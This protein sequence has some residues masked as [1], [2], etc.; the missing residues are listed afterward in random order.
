MA[1]SSLQAV[2]GRL[3]PATV[4]AAA[5]VAAALAVVVLVPT[6]ARASAYTDVLRAYQLNGSVPPCQFTSQQ[7]AA[8]LKEEDTY[9]QEYFADFT[10]A[11][12]AALSARAS[13][14]CNSRSAQRG[15]LP[16]T[17]GSGGRI[18]AASVTSST[19]ADLPAPIVLMAALAALGVL[20]GAVV[21]VANVRG[22]EPAWAATWRHAWSE[23]GYRASGTWSEFVDWLRS[24]PGQRS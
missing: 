3:A 23:A 22:F 17:A 1:M 4:A 5:F 19:G 2:T 6:V 16:G 24:G 11:I 21:A 20:V 7:L 9:G 10:N 14:Q 15:A 12:E 8:A 18:P 13:G